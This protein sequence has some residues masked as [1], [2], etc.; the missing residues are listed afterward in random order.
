MSTGKWGSPQNKNLSI[1]VPNMIIG[2][3]IDS[4]PTITKTKINYSGSRSCQRTRQRETWRMR[5]N[6]WIFEVFAGVIPRRP[7]LYPQVE[8]TQT[9]TQNKPPWCADIHPTLVPWPV[10]MIKCLCSRILT[11]FSV[12]LSFWTKLVSD[13][14]FSSPPLLTFQLPTTTFSHLV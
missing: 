6:F 12:F 13:F 5:A 14:I 2:L 11:V 4:W 9:H 7:S 8:N 3:L 1:L 10:S